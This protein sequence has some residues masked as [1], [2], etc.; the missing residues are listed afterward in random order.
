MAQEI[1]L[2]DRVPD[3]QSITAKGDPLDGWAGPVW[4]PIYSPLFSILTLSAN[5]SPSAGLGLQNLRDTSGREIKEHEEISNATDIHLERAIEMVARVRELT[6]TATLSGHPKCPH[7]SVSP[8]DATRPDNELLTTLHNG[9]FN[10]RKHLPDNPGGTELA[11][12]R[13]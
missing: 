2:S 6:S 3:G 8:T 11:A 4:H 13:E 9:P 10:L 1:E 7:S 12:I 5:L